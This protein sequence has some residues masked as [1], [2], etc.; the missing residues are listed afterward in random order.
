MK[1]VFAM[2]VMV[3]M[4]IVMVGC[5]A[6][7]AVEEEKVEPRKSIGWIGYGEQWDYGDG[8]HTAINI[9]DIGVYVG[10]N[11]VL[12]SAEEI[13]KKNGFIGLFILKNTDT[14]YGMKPVSADFV[15]YDW[16][17]PTKDDIFEGEA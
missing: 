7:K 15:A 17:Y 13:C 8:I 4:A 6:D 12:K 5:S 9:T 16:Y 14:I 3:V 2:M 11:Y 1:K 10:D